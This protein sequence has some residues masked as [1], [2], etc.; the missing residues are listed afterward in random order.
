MNIQRVQKEDPKNIF[1]FEIK[2]IEKNLSLIVENFSSMLANHNS[3]ELFLDFYLNTFL[4]NS[5]M[6]SSKYFEFKQ[7]TLDDKQYLVF[8]D[9]IKNISF[10]IHFYDPSCFP[11]FQTQLD[12]DDVF[13][14]LPSYI[15]SGK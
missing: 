15:L 9:K 2:T 10:H 3:N 4:K 6:K 12:F 14:D 5:K 13:T 1:R 8:I 11:S 7:E